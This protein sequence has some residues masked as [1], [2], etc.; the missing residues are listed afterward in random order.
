MA[1]GIPIFTIL[2]LFLA[3]VFAVSLF[4]FMTSFCAMALYSVEERLWPNLVDKLSKSYYLILLNKLLFLIPFFS[5]I[6]IFHSTELGFLLDNWFIYFF[7]VFFIIFGYIFWKVDQGEANRSFGNIF[8]MA[9]Y[10]C[11]FAFLFSI[12]AIFVSGFVREYIQ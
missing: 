6:Y 10:N 9:S 8:K 2:G 4:F 3:F 7:V 5:L 11:I 12:I 1:K